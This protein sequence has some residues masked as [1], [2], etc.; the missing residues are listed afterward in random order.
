[1]KKKSI[2]IITYIFSII[3]TLIV[4]NEEIDGVV[5]YASYPQGNEL[6]DSNIKVTSIYASLDGVADNTKVL[7]SQNLLPPSSTF[8]EVKGGNH[9][10]FGDYGSQSGDNKAI[11]S[12]EEQL[13]ISANASI[14]LLKSISK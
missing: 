2:K 1:M 4:V 12:M 7:D 9:A 5:F 8:V 6:K 3:L 13:A 10:Q 11:I 14:E